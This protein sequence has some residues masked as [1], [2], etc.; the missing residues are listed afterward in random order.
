MLASGHAERKEKLESKK[1]NQKRLTHVRSAVRPPAKDHR[2]Q[3]AAA[4]RE[5]LLKDVSVQHKAP[6]VLRVA[7]PS[8]VDGFGGATPVH[9]V[10]RRLKEIAFQH[11][12]L[13]GG[14]GC[15]E[16][17][18]GGDGVSLHERIEEALRCQPNRLGVSTQKVPPPNRHLQRVV[19]A[20][21]APWVNTRAQQ[22]GM[23]DRRSTVNKSLLLLHRPASKHL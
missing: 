11:N 10:L 1:L 5:A 7:S 12:R 17:L 22:S 13:K 23:Q 16:L 9:P 6:C 8:G 4:D 3:T 21:H 20:L 18:V 14:R 15:C 2:D 19:E